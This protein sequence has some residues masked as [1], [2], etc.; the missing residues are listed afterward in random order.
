MWDHDF[1][2]VYTVTLH[3]ETLKTDFRVVNEGKASF[4]F[5]TALHSYFEVAD[6]EKATIKGLKGVT[7][8][9]RLTEGAAA[10]PETRDSITFSGPVD[11][12]Y[13]NAGDYMELAVGTGA[14]VAISSDV[15][16]DS[17]V[18]SPWTD[19]K[20]CYKEFC[21]LEKGATTPVTVA[22]GKSWRAT[23]DL[24]VIDL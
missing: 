16:P 12:V 18:W 3:G 24:S 9:D 14:A 17:V 13:T 5:T 7:Y 8:T 4:D 23:M 21:C 10:T 1:K 20:D 15:W 22:A 6:I 2:L 11:S 19:M